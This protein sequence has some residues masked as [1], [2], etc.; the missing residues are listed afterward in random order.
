VW[1][2]D[3]YPGTEN[4]TLLAEFNTTLP[5]RTKPKTLSALSS[6]PWPRNSYQPSTIKSPMQTLSSKDM[7]LLQGGFAPL[8]PDPSFAGLSNQTREILRYFMDQAMRTLL[9][10]HTG[11][12]D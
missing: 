6:F 1:R 2:D 9:T 11:I 5:L 4:K 3:L 10:N 8:V 7:S 12:V